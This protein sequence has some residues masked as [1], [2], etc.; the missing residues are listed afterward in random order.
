M[1][2]AR[3]VLRTALFV[4]LVHGFF[5][6]GVPIFLLSSS[7]YLFNY[8]G[9]IRFLGG[10]SILT[11]LGVYMA[12]ILDFVRVGQGTPAVWDSP[13]VFVTR[14]P[15]RWVRN[16]MY[17]GMFLILMGEILFFASL[18]LGIYA[19]ALWLFFNFFVV[20]YEEPHLRKKFGPAYEAYL[21]KVPR[22]IPKFKK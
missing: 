10:V 19:G 7:A 21:K 6:V 16:P 18:L 20:W 2:F 22:W 11:G 5:L 8:P 13:T 1:E 14:G 17:V 3:L 4:V 15:Y 9:G 12:T